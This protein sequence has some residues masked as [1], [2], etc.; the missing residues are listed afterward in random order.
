MIKIITLLMLIC[1]QLYSISSA[2]IK[3]NNYHTYQDFAK[4][5]QSVAR[6][7]LRNENQ[8]NGHK[9]EMVYPEKSKKPLRMESLG[10]NFIKGDLYFLEFPQKDNG[11]YVSFNEEKCLDAV[12]IEVKKSRQG[13]VMF[14]WNEVT[15]SLLGMMITP[16]NKIDMNNILDVITGKIPYV[17]THCKNNQ[18]E[19]FY[20]RIK[21]VHMSSR[22]FYRV[23]I[24]RVS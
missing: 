2:G 13:A 9:F 23:A 8:Y 12:I 11:I 16:S 22:P 4:M 5:H 6:E 3:L 24:Y 17:D 7:I 10:L 1:L 21:D 18:N 19:S 14:T 20:L 15:N